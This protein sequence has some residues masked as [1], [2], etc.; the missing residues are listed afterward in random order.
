MTVMSQIKH[1][2]NQVREDAAW[3]ADHARLVKLNRSR[4]P[5]YAEEILAG[6]KLVTE[7]DADIHFV[8]KADPAATMAY[9]MA[10]DSVNFGSGYFELAQG[11]GIGLEYAPVAQHLKEAFIN[12]RMRDAPEWAMATAG[13]MHEIFK[14][15]HGRH[16]ALDQLMALFAK[17]L[18]I[19]GR[20]IIDDGYG[21]AE[22][23]VKQAGSATALVDIVGMWS[24][25]RDVAAYHGRTLAIYKRAQILAADIHLALSSPGNP[26]FADIGSVTIFADNMVPHVLRYDGII[27]YTPELAARIDAGEMIAAGSEEETEIRLVAIHA[28]EEMTRLVNE[29]GYT[30]IIAMNFD[31]L[32]WHR[33]YE[34][35]VY[36]KPRHKTLSVWY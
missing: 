35:A 9:F 12:G 33:G 21:S 26:F 36:A 15:P 16:P 19:T 4:L 11:A 34:P 22:N 25:F 18:Q 14:I 2:S 7:M 8:D 5:D 31:H 1:L 32:L 24:G 3:M 23:L 30:S 6:Y 17:H 13:Q 27:D 28:V 10:L 20:H 29:A